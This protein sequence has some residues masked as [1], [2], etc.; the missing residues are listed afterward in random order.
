M[1][2]GRF[3]VL[4]LI[5]GLPILLAYY[6]PLWLAAAI[7]WETALAALALA[8]R[9]S[10]PSRRALHARR[11]IKGDLV[12][13]I[14]ATVALEVSNESRRPVRLEIKDTPPAEFEV[15]RRVIAL[16]ISPN[17]RA[18]VNYEAL[19][20]K[21]G[22]FGFG[23]IY[24][25]ATGPLGLCISQYRCAAAS[26]TAAGPDVKAM[27]RQQLALELGARFA[28][29]RRRSR[30]IQQGTE[31]ARHR[32]YYPGDDY[33]RISW[34]AAARRGRL[35]TKEYETERSQSVFVLIDTGRMMTTRIGHYSR[36]DYAVNAA[37]QL[38]GACLRQRDIVGALAF[39]GEVK[40]FLA[41]SKG[42]SH[43]RKT[44]RFLSDLQPDYSEP[45]FARAYGYLLS[46]IS[47]RSLVVTITDLINPASAEA[48]ARYNLSIARRHL[49]LCVSIEDSDITAREGL[50]ARTAADVYR[51]VVA[52][53]M[54]EE[55]RAIIARL[56]KGG[57]LVV[58][59]PA[60]KLSTATVNRYLEVKYRNLL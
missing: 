34:K 46:R 25:R 60:D 28:F 50:R 54:I 40:G 33:R 42:K 12:Q 24:L 59:V 27:R 6:G 3:I 35:I 36:L 17:S 48:L 7:V 9:L 57:V 13:G 18:L 37:L 44:V 15:S 58:H 2:T 47:R 52:R 41:P 14:P 39:S 22:R 8:D 31:F 45:D 30:Y 11:L 43:W 23:D 16:R 19:S 1:V 55:A 4:W 20:Y 32:E 49:P 5:G 29:G 51:A 21:R 38:A 53:E 10:L 26:Q 56:E